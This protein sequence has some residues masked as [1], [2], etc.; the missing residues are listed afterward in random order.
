M[1]MESYGAEITLREDRQPV[2]MIFW[3]IS[4]QIWAPNLRFKNSRTTYLRSFEFIA[5]PGDRVDAKFEG[6]Q[7]GFKVEKNLKFLIFS[8][9]EE[10]DLQNLI[11]LT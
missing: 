6:S 7:N 5:E 8:W 2:L 1:P 9:A 11:F 4:P 10:G 3:L